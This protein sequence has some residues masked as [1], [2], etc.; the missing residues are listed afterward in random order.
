MLC[1]PEL[2][3]STRRDLLQFYDIGK[4]R[5]GEKVEKTLHDI[6]TGNITQTKRKSKL[7][8]FTK[9]T[10]WRETRAKEK[11]LS[12]I[13]SNAFHLLQSSGNIVQTCK[14]PLAISDINGSM[15]PSNKSTFKDAIKNI[16][17]L[18][19]MFVNILATMT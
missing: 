7:K 2:D 13:L 9:K 1:P 4:R 5:F 19:N 3:S 17:T 14:Y 18:A 6:Q 12:T 10:T 8:T 11:N 15:R 16:P